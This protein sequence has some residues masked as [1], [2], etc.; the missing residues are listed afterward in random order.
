[1]TTPP[2]PPQ[3]DSPGEFA[4]VLPFLLGHQPEDCIVLHGVTNT[5][6]GPSM[7]LHLPDDPATWQAAAEAGARKFHAIHDHGRFD[8]ND[9]VVFLCR[10]PRYG[11]S[12]EETVEDLWPLGQRLIDTFADLRRAPVKWVIALVDNRWWSYECPYPGCCEGEPIPGPDDPNSVTAQ[13]IRLGHTPGRS[14]SEITKEFQPSIPDD[15]SHLLRAL[16]NESTAWA[17]LCSGAPAELDAAL[18]PTHALLETTMRD[19]REGATEI[20]D[21]IAARL[22]HGLHDEWLMDHGLEYIEDDD[23]P[24]ARR[25]WAALARRCIP[26]YTDAAIPALTLLAAVAWRQDDIPTARHA[27]RQALTAD[28]EYSLAEAINGAINSGVDATSLLPI[29]RKAKAERHTRAQSNDHHAN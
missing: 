11:Q 26:P 27:L 10:T 19:F 29:A 25:L 12:P 5:G 9:I 28:P 24:H 2:S 23:L 4:Q 21:D 16:D 3:I 1:M 15:P 18:Q 17:Q 20:A 22:I 13:L 8:I 14:S 6:T 7:V